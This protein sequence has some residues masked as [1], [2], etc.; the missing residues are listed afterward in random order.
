MY[1]SRYPPPPSCPSLTHMP[2]GFSR[3]YVFNETQAIIPHR[4]SQ[5]SGN[6]SS[7]SCSIF[8]VGARKHQHI[9]TALEAV[10]HTPHPSTVAWLLAKT[11]AAGGH[12]RSNHDPPLDAYSGPRCLHYYLSKGSG[13]VASRAFVI[14]RYVPTLEV[15]V[16]H[17]H[18]QRP[19]WS[20]ERFPTLFYLKA[21]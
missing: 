13:L 10:T 2:C 9:C 21:E 6:A 18:R 12:V 7:A 8:C 15:L 11:I 19:R 14:F 1:P 5:G 16:G 17:L 3:L 4:K 20:P